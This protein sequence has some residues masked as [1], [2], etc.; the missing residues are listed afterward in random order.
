MTMYILWKE[1]Y[2][3]K[4]RPPNPEKKPCGGYAPQHCIEITQLAGHRVYSGVLLPPSAWLRYEL[5]GCQSD[6]S[7]ALL[8]CVCVAHTDSRSA[9]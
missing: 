3:R 5:R 6:K 8:L 9:V 2:K 1:D 7:T 4:R